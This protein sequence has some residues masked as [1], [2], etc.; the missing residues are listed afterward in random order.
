MRGADAGLEPL[1]IAR[2]AQLAPGTRLAPDLVLAGAWHLSSEGE[3]FG[4]YSALVP[5]PGGRFV[6]LSDRGWFLRFGDPSLP[7]GPKPAA[8]AVAHGNRSDKRQL[9]IEAATRDPASD[10]FWLAY[11]NANAIRRFG[12]DLADSQGVRPPAMQGWPSNRGPEAMVRL[13][14][15]RFVVLSEAVDEGSPLTAQ[16]LLFAGDPVDG[17]EPA[18]FRFVPPHGFR[19]TDMAQLPDGRVVILLRKLELAL[20]PR[21]GS[22]LIV[23]DPATIAAGREWTW[24]PLTEIGHPL[25]R[26]NYEG[27]AIEPRDGGVVR[28]WLISDDNG[29]ALQRTLLLALDW[30]PHRIE[31]ARR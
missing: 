24:E 13:S 1:R 10:T 11:E 14:D 22:R 30:M 25:P 18:P 9:D 16:G 31:P 27:L 7:S 26:E 8:G 2:L 29:A 19:V 28:L 17:S 6:A 21:I 20:P 4:G 3:V 5:M 15:G 12:P 23:A